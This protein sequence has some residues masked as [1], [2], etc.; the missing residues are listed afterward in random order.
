M[1]R[2]DIAKKALRAAQARRTAKPAALSG[3]TTP[4]LSDS[5]KERSPNTTAPAAGTARNFADRFTRRQTDT[6]DRQ[7]GVADTIKGAATT[8]AVNAA[9][10]A[11]TGGAAGA[12]R[13]VAVG[14]LKDKSSRKILLTL[15][16][17][18]VVTITLAIMLITSGISSAA[19]ALL[20]EQENTNS[21]TSAEQAGI[22]NDTLDKIDSTEHGN[23][24]W[25]VQA[26][27][28]DSNPDADLNALEA[29]L[30]ELDPP[31]DYRSFTVYAT[32]SSHSAVM[33]QQLDQNPGKD[34]YAALKDYHLQAF[35]A[36]GLSE[37][38]AS[39][40]YALA[41]RISLGADLCRAEGGGTVDP[42]GGFEYQGE[43]FTAAQVVNMKTI[44]GLAK[45][46]AG[47]DWEA[48]ARIGLI[49]VKVESGFR[50]YA[51]DGVVGPEDRNMGGF[52]A[53]DYAKLEYS[54]T[55]PHDAVGTDHASVGILQQQAT[56]GWGTVG[57]SNFRTDPEGVIKR[58]M[59]PAFAGARF[60]QRV[61]DIDR[62]QDADPGAIAQRVQVSAFPDKYAKQVPFADAVI[63]EFGDQ[64][65]IDV[66]TAIG[67]NGSGNSG[68][69]NGDGNTTQTCG[70]GT[71][72]GQL[73]TGNEQQLAQKILDYADQG[74][75][76]WYADAPEGY[77]QIAAYAAG[78][79]ISESCTLDPRVLQLLVMGAEMFN[80]IS[81]NSLNRR[82]TGSTPG[83]GTRSYH[84]KGQAADIGHLNG[85]STTGDPAIPEAHQFWQRFAE[86][87]ADSGGGLGQVQCRGGQTY[88]GVAN[89]DDACNH[90]HFE[91]GR[92]G[93]KTPL[94]G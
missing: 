86:V 45:T 89:F 22:T 53:D 19:V 20:D 13:A 5:T 39:S 11:V 67:W 63:A 73:P 59:D 88:E 34:Y 17:A 74:R 29:K 55:L 78:E 6:A 87:A 31:R 64:P 66:P 76:I 84:W 46:M 26:A 33:V 30:D 77:D 36:A 51:N 57:E 72:T 83:A 85:K 75:I 40:A 50:N 35:E 37:G 27:A 16:V 7:G 69:T 90:L 32:R 47:Q 28:L 18:L 79:P 68:D 15:L 24:P 49:T 14:A 2:R 56:M 44:I 58:L 21:R 25:P 81:I 1:E 10:G 42:S 43:K 94:K 93:N 54:L 23:L 41:T 82:C 70:E 48:A 4:E 52:T 3:T 80:K 62:W 60:L 65:G 9:K 12:V 38:D 71:P 8:A 61:M 91:I 92:G